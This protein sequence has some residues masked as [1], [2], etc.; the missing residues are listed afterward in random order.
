MWW[1]R[2]PPYRGSAAVADFGTMNHTRKQCY[3]VVLTGS[4]VCKAADPGTANFRT[5]KD[6][7][8]WRTIA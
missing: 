7:R 2:S 8:P 4:E 3:A 1:F 6:T 5:D